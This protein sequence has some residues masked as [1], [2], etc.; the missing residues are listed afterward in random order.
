[1]DS[2]LEENAVPNLPRA[3]FYAEIALSIKTAALP[4]TLFF[5][6]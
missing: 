1:M 2:F 5:P 4:V 3:K 6:F